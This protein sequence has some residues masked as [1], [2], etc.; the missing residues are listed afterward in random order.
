MRVVGRDTASV[1]APLGVVNLS[2]VMG[3]PTAATNALI[4][5]HKGVCMALGDES[6]RRWAG[7]R[8]QILEV[9]E[10]TLAGDELYDATLSK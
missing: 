8:L 10:D 9:N 2:D 5:D 3:C 4:I 6:A 7:G 1:R